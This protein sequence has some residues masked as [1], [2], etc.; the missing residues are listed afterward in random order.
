ML[1][2]K[3][4]EVVYKKVILVLRGVSL[5]VEEGQVA[6]LLGANGAG[7]STVLKAVSGLLRVELGEVTRGHVVFEG[8][9]IEKKDPEEIAQMG[10]RQVIEGRRLYTHLTTEENLR[11]G[12][13]L[14]RDRADVKRR[15]EQIY[16]YFPRLKLLGNKVSGYLSGGEQQMMVI[17]RSLMAR[18]RIL[19]LDEPSLGLAPLVVGEIFEIVRR[20]NEDERIGILLV[21]QNALAALGV[22]SYAYVMENGRVVLD[23]PSEKVRENEDVK[24][25]Y[26]GLSGV[27][28]K[29]SYRDVKHYKR[30]K[31]W[32]G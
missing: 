2:L 14:N 27:G 29:K 6:C 5:D 32:L 3:N 16:G 1:S 22:S 20:I 9:A 31:R 25:F 30:R 10:I 18:P 12:A 4:I 23:G 26:L 7:K 19:M 11:M 15:M 13:Y 17:G 24:E 28:K 8:R 21:E